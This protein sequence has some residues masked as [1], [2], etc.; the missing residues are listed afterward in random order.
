MDQLLENDT[1][2]VHWELDE[3]SS[4]KFLEN[5]FPEDVLLVKSLEE[6]S[7]QDFSLQT[8]PALL[9]HLR[10]QKLYGPLANSPDQCGWLSMAAPSSTSSE[11]Y[12]AS[13]F[14]N[15]LEQVQISIGHFIHPRYVGTILIA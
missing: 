5:L 1:R 2:G 6:G 13:F 14:N 3:P 12:I 9:G 10:N 15:L 11:E 8:I 4:K 7:F